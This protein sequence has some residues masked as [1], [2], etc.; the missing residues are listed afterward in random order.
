MACED[1]IISIVNTDEM[2]QLH[3]VGYEWAPLEIWGN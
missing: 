2:T 1:G 3:Q